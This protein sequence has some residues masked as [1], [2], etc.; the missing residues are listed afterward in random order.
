MVDEDKFFKIIDKTF[1][2]YKENAQPDE[3]FRNTI[4]RVGF[5]NYKQSVLT[6]P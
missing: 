4:D 5:E 1:D 6:R 2:F 3:R